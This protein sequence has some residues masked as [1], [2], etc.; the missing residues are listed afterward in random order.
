VKDRRYCVLKNGRATTSFAF[1]S[2]AISGIIALIFSF[3]VRL[4]GLA[5]FAPESATEKFISIV[6]ASIEQPM[7]Q[8]LGDTAGLLGLAIASIVAIIVY[9]AFGVLFERV[10]SP[11]ISKYHSLT[12]MEQFL[13]YS[14]IPWLF[15]GLV[16]FPVSGA[17]LFGVNAPVLFAQYSAVLSPIALLFSAFLFSL[18]LATSYKAAGIF[19]SPIVSSTVAAVKEGPGIISPARRVF[20]ERSVII[21]GAAVLALT[22][23]GSILFSAGTSLSSSGS[24]AGSPYDLSQAPAIF[25]DKRLSSLVDSEITSNANFYRVAIDLFDPSVNV[26]TWNLKVTGSNNSKSYTLND[27]KRLPRVSQYTTFECVSNPVN[28]NLISNAQWTGVKIS[29][30]FSD[31]GLDLTGVQYVVFYSV[32]GY[33]VGIPLSRA[34]MLDSILAYQMNGVDLPQRHG[35]P[36]RA[37]IPGLYGMMS[38]KWVNAITLVDS[39]YNGY[40]QTRGY[41]PTAAINT[42]AF[43]IIPGDGAQV[44]LSQNSGSILLGGYAF[45]GDRGISKVELSFDQGQTWQPAILKPP[46]SNL[47]WT[48]WAFN[49]VPSKTGSYNVYARATDGTGQLQTSAEAPPYPNGATGYAVISIVVTN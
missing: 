41:T 35:Y 19:E 36:L 49:W 6:P 46:I 2:G 37:V 14:T 17:G 1:K 44:S 40:W 15:F 11:W 13:A 47:T 31:A 27:L 9:G 48:L 33:N 20:V 28:G 39:F 42:L 34:M 18:A 24:R 8:A 43:I 32:D 22:S 21:A 30:L 16:V 45:A 7:I 38:A 3:I 29:D 23:I 26:N 25:Q 5:P 12:R 4:G 10:Y